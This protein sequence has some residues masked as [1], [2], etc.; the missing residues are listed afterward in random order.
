MELQSGTH[1]TNKTLR[2]LK[3]Q[4]QRAS[5][6]AGK[7]STKGKLTTDWRAPKPD[8]ET[9]SETAQRQSTAEKKRNWLKKKKKSGGKRR[10]KMPLPPIRTK[11]RPFENSRRGGDVC[12]LLTLKRVVLLYPHTK[13][14]TDRIHSNHYKSR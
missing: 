14:G 7:P 6:F 9:A 11:K 5:R 2:L 1:S 4:K 10:T 3:K 8:V 12:S 13:D